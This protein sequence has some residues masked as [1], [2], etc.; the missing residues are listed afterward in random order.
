MLVAATA[1]LDAC[2]K[3]DLTTI[4]SRYHPTYLSFKIPAG[5]P[6]PPTDI[7]KTNPLTEEGFQLGKKLFYDGR[8]SKDGS[9]QHLLP[10]ITSLAMDSIIVLHFA[11]HLHFLIWHG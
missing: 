11:T 9:L 3:N 1:L 8:L 4:S 2:K 7:F 10:M 6:Q 5:W